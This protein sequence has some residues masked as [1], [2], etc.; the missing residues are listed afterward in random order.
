MFINW[1]M[2][3]QIIAHPY[4]VTE[5]YSAVSR[6]DLFVYATTWTNLEI[7]MLNDSVTLEN[8]NYSVVTK[9]K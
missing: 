1:L 9:I 8:A 7:I 2:N 4:T 6:N 3:K 5:Y